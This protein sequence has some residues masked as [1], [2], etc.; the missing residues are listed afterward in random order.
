MD[1]Q[2]ERLYISMRDLAAMIGKS[3]ITVFRAVKARKIKS[4]R[5]GG[6]VRIP[7]EEADRILK[8]GY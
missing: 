6:R 2:V 7:R 3:Y 5:F 8:E 1:N 4:V